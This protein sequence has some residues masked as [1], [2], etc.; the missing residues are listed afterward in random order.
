MQTNFDLT[1]LKRIS[2]Q[3]T[4]KDGLIFIGMGIMLFAMS[5]MMRD[6]VFICFLPLAILFN[7]IVLQNL[8]QKYTYPRLGFV[9]PKK[10]KSKDLILI[11]FNVGIGCVFILITIILLFFEDTNGYEIWWNLLTLGISII[12]GVQSADFGRKTGNLIYYLGAALFVITGLFFSLLENVPVEEKFSIYLFLWGGALI[13]GG[14]ITF[15]R[16]IQTHPIMVNEEKDNS[17]DSM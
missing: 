15:Y 8:K 12:L 6:I 17:V 16:F 11:I 4:L 3:N 9:Q 7:P 10:E 5:M 2:H 1:N 14:L 13:G